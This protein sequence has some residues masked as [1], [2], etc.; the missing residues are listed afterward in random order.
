DRPLE[1]INAYA[2][3]IR[4]DREFMLAYLNRGPRPR[5]AERF[6]LRLEAPLDEALA[7][8]AARLDLD[9]DLDRGSLSARGILPGEIVRATVTGATRDQLLDAVVAPLGLRWQVEGRRLRVAAPSP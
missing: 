8:L 9:L 6:T 2:A 4:R 5:D 1:A 3:S 7:A